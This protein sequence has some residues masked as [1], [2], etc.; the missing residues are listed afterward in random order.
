MLPSTAV[1]PMRTPLLAQL[2][3]LV[4]GPRVPDRLPLRV[5]AAIG[6]EQD[7]SEIIVTLLQ[8]VAIVTFAVL[9]SLTPKGFPPSVRFEPSLP[10]CALYASDPAPRMSMVSCR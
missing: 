10:V 1:E 6:R 7:N 8:F 3:E 5:Q 2:Q 4:L 9:Y